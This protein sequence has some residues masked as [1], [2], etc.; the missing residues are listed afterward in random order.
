MGI[1]SLRE[2]TSG[3]VTRS[4]APSPSERIAYAKRA[5]E[6]AEFVEEAAYWAHR[7]VMD[8]CAKPGDYVAAMRRASEKHSIPHGTLWTLR[9]RPPRSI[10]V[11]DYF[12]ILSSYAAK[13]SN[14]EAKTKIGATLLN[15]AHEISKAT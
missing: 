12:A 14:A 10:G 13:R 5:L 6:A 7:L 3:A 1:T 9:Y 11:E 15:V 2:R 8:E 4:S